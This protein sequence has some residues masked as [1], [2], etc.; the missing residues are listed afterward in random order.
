MLSAYFI[1]HETSKPVDPRFNTTI[2]VVISY[3]FKS[4]CHQ[5]PFSNPPRKSSST[6]RPMLNIAPNLKNKGA[7]L[8]C[9]LSIVEKPWSGK[10]NHSSLCLLLY[11]QKLTV[12]QPH[13]KNMQY[14]SKM[15]DN[16]QMPWKKRKAKTH[17]I[18]KDRNTHGI[19]SK[20]VVAK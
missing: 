16:D 8:S 14:N 2:Q 9:N 11:I 10:V 3:P 12:A 20:L 17:G 1:N 15:E 7:S 6:N 5:G 13:V 18:N 4:L 19:D